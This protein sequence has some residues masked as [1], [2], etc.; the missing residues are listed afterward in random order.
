GGLVQNVVVN[1]SVQFKVALVR[2][3]RDDGFVFYFDTCNG[4][5]LFPEGILHADIKAGPV[6]LAAYGQNV[7]AQI[8][9]GA[10]NSLVFQVFLQPVGHIAFGNGS[11]VH[12]SSRVHELDGGAVHPDVFVVHMASGRFDGSSVRKRSG[13]IFD[14]PQISQRRDS[15]I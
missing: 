7:A 3:G 2:T 15:D 1:L 5:S 10:G 13:I 6:R 4:L 9:K 8:D 12:R 11:Q 14:V